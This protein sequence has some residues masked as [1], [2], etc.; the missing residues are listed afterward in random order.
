ML[1]VEA[2]CL[3]TWW[4]AV[5]IPAQQHRMMFTC[6]SSII[7]MATSHWLKSGAARHAGDEKKP[8]RQ[9]RPHIIV[10]KG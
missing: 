3:W 2:P 4:G 1:M 9:A 8:E 5:L 7:A 6:N 10:F